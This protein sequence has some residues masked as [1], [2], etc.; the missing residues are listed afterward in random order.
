V[1][2]HTIFKGALF[3]VVLLAAAGSRPASAAKRVLVERFAGP[4]TVALRTMVLATFARMDA[5]V[6]PDP[7]VAT[8][9][10]EIGVQKVEEDDT[11]LARKLKATLLV[12]GAIVPFKGGFAIMMSGRGPDGRQLTRPVGWRGRT[13]PQVLGKAKVA[14]PKTL[15]LMLTRAPESGGAAPERRA[16]PE[17]PEKSGDAVDALLAEVDKPSRPPREAALD[18]EPAPRKR[19]AKEEEEEPAAKVAQAEEPAPAE[20]EAPR[21]RRKKRVVEADDE[22]PAPRKRSRANG[23]DDE[24]PNLRKKARVAEEET[25]GANRLELTVGA[26]VYGRSFSYNQSLIGDHDAYQLSAVPAPSLSIDYYV[27]PSLALTAGGE[28][29][30]ALASQRGDGGP[31]YKTQASSYF[32]GG[33]YRYSPMPGWD[34]MAGAAYAANSFRIVAQGEDTMPPHVPGVAYRQAR[35]GLATRIAVTPTIS[36]FGGADYLHLLGIGELREVYFPQAKGRGGSGYAGGAYPLSFAKGLEARV[37]VDLRRYVFSMN[38]EKG[39]DHVAGGAID[40]YVG[41]NVGV[42]YRR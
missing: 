20:E 42:G 1:K 13:V 8:A 19:A 34:L 32:A 41:I 36:L 31:T 11:L 25:G 18:E 7:A 6:I 2:H 10:K 40:Q 4:G 35:I 15:G 38:P 24:P 39:D 33:K 9:A 21:P 22:E 17:K 3:S 29:A 14:L 12:R 30:F 26:H 27:T 37:T 16:R 5:E 28:I 23:D